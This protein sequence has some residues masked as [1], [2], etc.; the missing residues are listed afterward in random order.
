MTVFAKG[1]DVPV[2]RSRT[3]IE[4]MLA[5]YGATK[6]ASGWDRTNA[7]IMCEA[8]GRHLRFVLPIPDASDKAFARD[9]R[10][11]VRTQAHRI[12]AADAEARRRWRA[13]ALVIKAKLEAVSTGITSFEEEF[14]AHIVVPGG[15]TFA[16]WA[17]PQ[18]AE[19]YERAGA[20]PPLL[21]PAPI[22]GG[23]K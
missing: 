7:V 9:G 17:L 23:S 12:K 16:E 13:L 10:G 18:I 22:T 14:L 8:N 6:F 3:E 21:G 5:R 20:L 4:S 1:T 11:S 19:G 15:K 2:T